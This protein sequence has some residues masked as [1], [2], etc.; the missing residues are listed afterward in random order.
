MGGGVGRLRFARNPF[1][2]VGRTVLSKGHRIEIY[3]TREGSGLRGGAAWSLSVEV[4]RRVT[5]I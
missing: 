5:P 4:R 2:H 1:A 3:G